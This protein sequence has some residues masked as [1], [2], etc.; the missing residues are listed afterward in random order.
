M[1]V[2]PEL[3]NTQDP[4]DIWTALLS[5]DKRKFTSSSRWPFF[6]KK[7]TSFQISAQFSASLCNIEANYQSLEWLL[8]KK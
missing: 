7:R 4:Q 6:A 5:V 2:P 8:E 1:E 3:P